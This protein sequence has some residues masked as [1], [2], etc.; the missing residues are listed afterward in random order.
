MHPRPQ[1]FSSLLTHL[2][3]A[4]ARA[5]WRQKGARMSCWCRRSQSPSLTT[6][7]HIGEDRVQAWDVRTVHREREVRV[8]K[9]IVPKLV[10]LRFKDR[11]VTGYVQA[12]SSH[13]SWSPVHQQQPCTGAGSEK[14]HEQTSCSRA[15]GRRRA[16][17]TGEQHGDASHGKRPNEPDSPAFAQWRRAEGRSSVILT[18]RVALLAGRGG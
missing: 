9:H 6:V 10:H 7:N 8:V 12:R 4:H 15:A 14:S 16:D 3:N 17:L 13:T 1:P 11:R 18:V 2:R 5:H